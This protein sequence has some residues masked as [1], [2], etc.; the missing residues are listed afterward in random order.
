MSNVKTKP[1]PRQP[2]D[3]TYRGWKEV[4][5]FEEEDVLTAEDETVDLLSRGS[6]F[7]QYLPAAIYGDWYHNTGYL[8]V[9]GLLSWIIGWFRFSVAPL[10]LSWWCFLCC[11][12]LPLKVQRCLERAS[13]T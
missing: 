9:A 2:V 13:T 5:G 4:G 3:P 12:V 1:P 10:F 7:D 6:L 8:I 11:I